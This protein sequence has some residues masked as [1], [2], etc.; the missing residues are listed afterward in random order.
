MIEH[1][2][3]S[4]GMNHDQLMAAARLVRENCA[5][6]AKERAMRG[7]VAFRTGFYK[8]TACADFMINEYK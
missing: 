2:D 7:A 4:M 6:V 3:R 1:I 5:L 8:A